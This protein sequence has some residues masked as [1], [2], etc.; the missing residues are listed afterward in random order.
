MRMPRLL[1]VLLTTCVA[2]V[3]T[4][5]GTA[6]A[7]S[8]PT[9]DSTTLTN[10]GKPCSAT[11]PPVVLGFSAPTLQVAGS[12]D[13]YSYSGFNYTFAIWPLT[14]PATVRTMTR[15]GSASGRLATAEVPYG[16]LIDGDS[17]AWRVQLATSNGT[18]PWSQVCTFSYDNTPPPTPA[19]SSANY[20]AYGQG[21][22]PLGEFAQF[23]F[24][25]GGDPDTAGFYYSWSSSP[26]AFT[27][28]YSGPI[29]QLVCPDPFSQPDTVRVASPGGTASVLLNPVAN[30]P[31]TLSVATV[32]VAGN[33]SEFVRYD[34]FVPYSGPDVTQAA[35]HPI[36]GSLA[37]VVFAPRPGLGP[38]SSYTYSFDQGPD[39]TVPAAADGTAQVSIKENREAGTL[40]VTS[41]GTNGFRS[42]D[43]Y[44][45][46]DV[47]PQVSVYSDVYGD[48][49]QPA[50]GVGVSGQFTLWPP[51]SDGAP[52]TAF[53]YR[54]SDGPAK[55]VAADEYGSATVRWAPTHAG[56]QTMTV[57]SLNADGSPASCTSSYTFTVAR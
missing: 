45:W 18:S 44:T 49:G 3:L 56:Q 31:Q 5:L 43:A 35:S 50:G 19:V 25:A 13:T 14:D 27:C 32:D 16:G 52:P 12:D 41:T 48:N 42:S 17:Y 26:P 28:S 38:V 54:F 21:L 51:Y 2:A 8:G 30:G 1:A 37:K 46:L 47:N 34:T 55:T 57:Q 11:T 4:P 24:D 15:F 9:I 22:A 10:G 53:S 23:T 40:K 6:Q 7:A 29:G 33:R 39:V 20:P 36:C